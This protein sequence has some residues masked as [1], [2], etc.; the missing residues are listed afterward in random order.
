MAE[1]EA[2]QNY[3]SN[4]T[5][6]GIIVNLLLLSIEAKLAGLDWDIIMKS[7]T[8]SV[9]PE[10]IDEDQ[11]ETK[12]TEDD[13]SDEKIEDYL[14]FGNAWRQ[15]NKKVPVEFFSLTNDLAFSNKL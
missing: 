15:I 1:N 8:D 7:V 5:Q 9:R 11:D 4:M 14:T 6:Y 3:I 2:T 13:E 12:K 10:P